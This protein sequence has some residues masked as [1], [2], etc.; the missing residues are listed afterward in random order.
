MNKNKL[1]DIV[2]DAF[3][4]FNSYRLEELKEDDNFYINALMTYIEELESRTKELAQQ[5]EYL[6]TKQN[7]KAE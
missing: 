4:Y 1:I 6:K 2:D 7:A 5:T 3:N